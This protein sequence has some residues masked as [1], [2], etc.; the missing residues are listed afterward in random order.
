M[1]KHGYKPKWRWVDGV[2]HCFINR[3]HLEGERPSGHRHV[4]LC[5][6]FEL[7]RARGAT[8]KRPPEHMRCDVCNEQEMKMM[9]W[10]KPGATSRE[11][12]TGYVQSM[13][14]NR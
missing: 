9:G 1:K 3:S 4:S 8:V 14:G 2:S 5:Q 10:S 12:G 11:W 6:N 13:M 7:D